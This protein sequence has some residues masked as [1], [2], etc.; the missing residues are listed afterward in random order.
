MICAI[1]MLQRR[2]ARSARAP[3]LVEGARSRGDVLQHDQQVLA[4]AER[5][6][7]EISAIAATLDRLDPTEEGSIRARRRALAPRHVEPEE[8]ARSR[9]GD[10]LEPVG[11]AE[12][13]AAQQGLERLAADG[14][15]GFAG[16][17]KDVADHQFRRHSTRLPVGAR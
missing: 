7:E 17:R 6:S 14:P 9:A 11:L 16:H 5:A 13:N 10:D 2:S 15:R 12:C 1:G 4:Q 3:G 8:P